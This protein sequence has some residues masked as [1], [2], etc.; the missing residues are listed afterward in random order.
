MKTQ[1]ARYLGAALLAGSV[2]VPTALYASTAA[3]TTISNTV[4]VNFDDASGN[5][6]TAVVASVSFSVNLV[7]SAPIVSA[8][9]D[10]NPATES[11][12]YNLVHSLTS[13]ANGPDTYNIS[14]ASVDSNMDGSATFGGDAT[15]V[16]GA[17]TL[18]ADFAA[19][20]TTITV[21]FD[22]TDDGVVNG[23]AAGDLIVIDPTGTGEPAVIDSIDESTGAATNVVT[24]TL[25][26]ATVNAATA[27]ITIGETASTTTTVTTNTVTTP[28]SGTHTVTVTYTSAADAGVTATDD[29][30]YTVVRSAL[31]VT[32]YVRNATTANGTGTSIAFGGETYYDSGVNGN[33]GET[34]EYLIVIE[35]PPTYADAQNIVV[36]DPIPQF[37]T[38]TAAT[39]QL[40]ANGGGLVAQDDS[41]SGDAAEFDGGANI[42]YVYAGATGSDGAAGFGNGT[43]GTL[44]GGETSAVIFQVT[45]D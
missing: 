37:T 27:G 29:T 19:G 34:M 24:I 3:N 11:T 40:D 13:T 21:P 14:G 32:K 18:A 16:L 39:I 35:N 30:V 23:L 4:T 5:A 44:A 12:L 33:P 2:F 36:S 7:A 42:V 26:A 38:Y 20:V 43:G 9:A 31:T 45:I 1:A 8:P 17:T 28:P 22:G 41:D 25:T 6:Q 10:V 15:I